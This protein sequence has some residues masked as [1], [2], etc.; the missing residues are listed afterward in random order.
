MS[1]AERKRR[2]RELLAQAQIVAFEVHLP[3]QVYA[4]LEQ[5]QG[6]GKAFSRDQVVQAAI[7]AA[8]AQQGPTAA[9][10]QPDAHL[11]QSIGQWGRAP[12]K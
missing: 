9:A 6:P 10:N 12:R 5:L 8:F 3:R 11:A 7:S 2:S 4:Q 1:P